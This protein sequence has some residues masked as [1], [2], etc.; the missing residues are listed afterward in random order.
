M[1]NGDGGE[2]GKEIRGWLQRCRRWRR[3]FEKSARPR[4]SNALL[5]LTWRQGFCRFGNPTLRL[6]RSLSLGPAPAIPPSAQPAAAAAAGRVSALTAFV[7][8]LRR[9][10]VHFLYASPDCFFK[11]KPDCLAPLLLLPPSVTHYPP[12]QP[13]SI[14]FLSSRNS[15][16][17]L[18]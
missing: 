18:F 7:H 10:L 9:S 17:K 12:P 6:A 2:D 8:S 15:L 4:F 1:R 5:G 16:I 13:L 3:F 11:S 14:C